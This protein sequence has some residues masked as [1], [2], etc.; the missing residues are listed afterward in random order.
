MKI[1]GYEVT[2]ERITQEPAKGQYRAPLNGKTVAVSRSR[3][4]VLSNAEFL[5]KSMTPAMFAALTS[6]MEW[7]A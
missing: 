3:K 6:P 7:A 5:A 2:V 4:A 1:Q